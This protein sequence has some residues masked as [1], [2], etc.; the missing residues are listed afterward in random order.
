[1]A[2]SKLSVVETSIMTLAGRSVRV[3]IM[4][5]DLSTSPDC[6]PWV[7]A[8]RDEAR[9]RAGMAS[10]AANAVPEARTARRVGRISLVMWVSFAVS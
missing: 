2:L 5:E 4:P 9:L 3:Q 8:G 1:M 10:V 7:K 6:T